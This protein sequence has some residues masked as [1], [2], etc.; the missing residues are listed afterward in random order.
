MRT[1]IFW[2]LAVVS[3]VGGAVLFARGDT[4]KTTEGTLSLR[5]K[6][7]KVAQAVAYETTI[8]GDE[9]IVVVTG[10]KAMTSAKLKE[11]RAADEED[12]VPEF[13]RP[14]LR[15]VFKKTGEL[16]DWGAADNNTS[17]RKMTGD[18]ATGE[19]TVREGRAVGKASRASNPGD[20]LPSSFAVN[21]DAALQ[22][23][24][25]E[26]PE[27]AAASAKPAMSKNSKTA[28]EPKTAASDFANDKVSALMRSAGVPA[29][30]SAETAIK[31][32]ELSLPK[33]AS[34]VEY[35]GQAGQQ[36]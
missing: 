3:V 24:G 12:K 36:R 19:L 9:A 16:K 15:L 10:T 34:A 32:Q 11:A 28:K 20:M 1:T 6:T 29:G 30:K 31:A 7:H 4:A 35:N 17:T 27:P 8:D 23:L 26:L 2:R 21:F 13:G 25:E 5:T 22:K 14:Y 18:R 33:D